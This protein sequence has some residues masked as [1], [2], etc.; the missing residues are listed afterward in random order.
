M[1]QLSA[2]TD[3]VCLEARGA[4]AGSFLTA[5]LSQTLVPGVLDHAPLAGWHDAR[6]RVRA[7]VRVWPLADRWL[8]GTPRDGVEQLLQRLRMFILRA[9][10]TL[11]IAEDVSVA[12][13]VGADR[14]WLAGRALPV[15]ARPGTVVAQGDVRWLCVGPGY[16]Q[17][18]GPRAAID[19]LE[20]TLERV[21]AEAAALAEIGLGLPAI[22]PAL[23]DRF[24]AQMLNLDELGALAFD[25]GCYPGQ[26]VIARVR[27][28]GDV[29]RRTRRYAAAVATPA[30]VGAPVAT[31]KGTVLGEVVRSAPAEHGCELLAVVDDAASDAQLMI[32]GV[33]LRELPLPFRVRRD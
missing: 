21:P 6:G 8:L 33:A 20:P 19:A 28:L 24:V 14:E 32:D 9:A 23:V 15:A 2:L 25:K 26:E 29:K 18:L 13:V 10:V 4:D 22:T 17:A 16:W 7:L 30:A 1:P 31:E 12:A 5:Q 27:H 3:H 11:A